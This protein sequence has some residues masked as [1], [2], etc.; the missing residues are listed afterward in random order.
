M[1]NKRQQRAQSKRE[2]AK[3]K[4]AEARRSR[5]SR[6]GP[7]PS[8]TSGRL[9]IAECAEWPTG[10]CYL[11]DNWHEHGPR[12][13]AAFTRRHQD[14]RIAAAFFEADL[15]AEGIVEAAF[16][17][18]VSEDMVLSEVARRS[19]LLDVPMR[20]DSPERIA[21]VLSTARALGEGSDPLVLAFLDGVDTGACDD[22]ILTGEPPPPPP[23]KRNLFTFLFGE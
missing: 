10:E 11:S 19:E 18:P 12:I 16:H 17:A 7:S 9:G 23:K 14:G 20:L 8:G 2:K 22:V 4:R 6:P 5:G 13:V 3:K 15:R 21:K 1:G